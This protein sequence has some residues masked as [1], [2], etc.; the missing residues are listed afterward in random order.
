MDR[1]WL[2]GLYRSCEHP[3]ATRLCWCVIAD[4]EPIRRGR[5]VIG[6]SH[7]L[8]M[9]PPEVWELRCRTSRRSS[10]KSLHQIRPSHTHSPRCTPPRIRSSP[11]SCP[12]KPC[13]ADTSYNSTL[14]RQEPPPYPRMNPPDVWELRCRTVTTVASRRSSTKSRQRI[15]P[16][17]T[18]S[19]RC[20]PLLAWDRNQELGSGWPDT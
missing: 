16:S 14:L 3:S 1:D 20:I 4:S 17:H 2:P 13:P 6:P 11:R 19:H 8:R 15:H 10:S 5:H 12:A 7:Y 18:R 9:N